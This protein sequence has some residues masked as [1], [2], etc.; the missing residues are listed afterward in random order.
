MSLDSRRVR[1]VEEGGGDTSVGGGVGRVRAGMA[2]GVPMGSRW[3]SG[4]MER[5]S[6]WRSGREMRNG[7]VVPPGRDATGPFGITDFYLGADQA[8]R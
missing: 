4:G 8:E 5:G 6:Q 2:V 3:R 7:P 1:I